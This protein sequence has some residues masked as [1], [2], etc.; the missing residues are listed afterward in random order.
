MKQFKMFLALFFYLLFL[1]QIAFL[2]GENNKIPISDKKNKPTVFSIQMHSLMGNFENHKKTVDMIKAAGIKQ[3]RDELFWH[4]V[5]KS[6]GIYKIPDAPL[7]NLDYSIQA[8]LET[9]IILDYGNM[10]YDEGKAPTSKEA[11]QSFSE[12]AFTMAKELK[13][14]VKYFEIWNEPNVD[15]FWKPKSDPS[16]Y[17]NLLKNA[18]PAIKRGNPEA[19]VL[20]VSLAGI[21][22]EFIDQVFKL[23][24]YDFMDIVS[25][26]PYCTPKSPE[27][28]KIFEKMEK[29]YENFKKYGKSKPIWIT[30]VG[31]PTNL[32]GGISEEKQANFIARQYLLTLAS[33]FIETTFIYWFGPD[34]PDATWAEDCFGMLHEDFSPKPSYI[35]VKTL[36]TILKDFKYEK[37]LLSEN[38]R[39]IQFNKNTSEFLTALWTV[40]EYIDVAI[41]TDKKIGIVLRDGTEKIFF[42]NDRRIILTASP[43]PIYIKSDQSL[44]IQKLDKNFLETKLAD[45]TNLIPRGLSKQIEINRT[46]EKQITDNIELL[47]KS[48]EIITI[49][50]AQNAAKNIKIISTSNNATIKKDEIYVFL[51]PEDKKYPYLL[52]IK[53]I[54][55]HEPIKFHIFPLMP[56]ADSKEFSLSVNNT[57]GKEL[58][59]EIK[60]IAEKLFPEIQ[61]KDK[62][63][64]KPSI[65]QL[66]QNNIDIRSLPISEP[67]E[68]KINI[69]TP[70][71]SDSLIL[72][73]VEAIIEENIK[74]NHEQLIDFYVSYKTNNKIII[75]GDL[76][77]WEKTLEP[78]NIC[79]AKQY[80][81]G[82][83][84]WGGIEDASAK[85]FTCYDE[86]YFYIGVEFIDDIYSDPVTGFG[87]YNNDGCE[88]YFDI[89][90]FSDYMEDF[91]SSDD[92]QYGIF[93][94]QGNDIVYS[95]SQLKGESKNSKIRINRKP[96]KNQTITSNEYK[97]M[98][99]EAAIPL[100]ELNLKPM[101]RNMMRFNA[102]LTDDD[103]PTSVHPFFQEI[104]MTWTG[105][106]NSWQNPQSFGFLFFR[107][108]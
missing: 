34:G 8:G 79:Y 103:D 36:N 97:G 102:A 84:K 83:V 101:E 23:G 25:L 22:P 77:D 7:K 14:K 95:W 75:N 21:E 87:I 12:Y 76:S 31:W 2:N 108:N 1:S 80:T 10:F 65:I 52:S 104:Q 107:H 43:S 13:G 57:S 92:Y 105:K 70:L 45:G 39:A 9:L 81:G 85:I 20:G 73:K 49:S 27:E 59:C 86:K 88:I 29:H 17:V 55:I 66:S 18:Y 35:A 98:I 51:T 19:I 5:E 82:Y 67:K 11:L 74:I 16:A 89:D 62:T 53:E 3:V 71:P 4:E 38:I 91:Y 33:S 50:D 69:N 63:T 60:I 37:T 68:F 64:I 106:K 48:P 56:R 58:K 42:P 41:E 94:S 78:I 28:A 46:D 24:G 100:D 99:I 26:H 72:I 61:D 15:G 96:L 30:E 32:G 93:P 90:Y 6:K 47:T 44:K 54:E 40:E